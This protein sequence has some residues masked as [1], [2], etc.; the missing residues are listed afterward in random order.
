MMSAMNN[1]VEELKQKNLVLNKKANQA[2]D[3]KQG[4]KIM[5]NKVSCSFMKGIFYF[6]SYI[7]IN[8]ILM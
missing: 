6:N 5:K 7:I 4:Y 1:N 8:S 2:E 3:W